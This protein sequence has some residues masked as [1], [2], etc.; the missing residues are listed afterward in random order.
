M[1]LT[2]ARPR[3]SEEHYNLGRCLVKVFWPE[4]NILF[5]MEAQ[6]ATLDRQQVQVGESGV[7]QLLA[8]GPEEGVRMIRDHDWH[9]GQGSL[10]DGFDRF[11]KSEGVRVIRIRKGRIHH[12]KS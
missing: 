12:D 9:D 4:A 1:S 10:R 7:V 8:E 5:E 2:N 3:A 11:G 6:T